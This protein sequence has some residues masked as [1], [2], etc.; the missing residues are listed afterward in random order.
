MK[1]FLL[2][3]GHYAGA[4]LPSLLSAFS[5]G[6]ALPVTGLDIFHITDRPADPILVPMIRD[7]NQAHTLFDRADN[8][9]FFPSSFAY[10]SF[11]PELPSISTLS[12]DPSSAA[13]LTALRGKGVPL[14]YKTDRE[15]VEWAFSALL[16]SAD[17]EG[18]RSLH[19]FLDK[20][21]ACMSSGEDFRVAVLCDL[22]DPFSSGVAFALLRFLHEN[23]K[24]DSSVLSLF[25]L[26]VSTSA[27]ADE[28]K[29]LLSSSLRALAGQNLV[30]KPDHSVPACADAVWLL[31]L[32]SSM[33][34]SDDSLRILYTVL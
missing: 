18:L 17:G 5:C 13:L 31:S 16:S 21:K 8:T 2:P 30:G 9:S 1:S 20:L 15:A 25:C 29:D 23:I 10:A 28:A 4:S 7:L 24:I 19:T 26:A 32:P 12:S 11:R 27:T 22:C 6:A 34:R 3:V 33:V 14:S